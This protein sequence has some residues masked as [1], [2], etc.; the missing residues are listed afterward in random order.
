MALRASR[1]KQGYIAMV[2]ENGNFGAF[3][4]DLKTREQDVHARETWSMHNN[5]GSD[6]ES[7][8]T[9]ERKEKSTPTKK[10]T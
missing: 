7:R 2:S 5:P 4:W 8:D 3:F 6:L 10:N 1:S 9:E